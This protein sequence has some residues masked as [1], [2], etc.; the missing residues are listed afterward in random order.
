MSCCDAQNLSVANFRD[1]HRIACGLP[2]VERPSPA[3]ANVNTSY[4]H[5]IACS[6]CLICGVHFEWGKAPSRMTVLEANTEHGHGS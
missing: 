4:G 1:T 3:S 2:L 6:W 5:H